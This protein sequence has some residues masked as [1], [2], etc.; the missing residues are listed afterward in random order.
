MVLASRALSNAGP[1]KEDRCI[2]A[3]C[4]L[5]GLELT[6]PAGRRAR[7]TQ[8]AGYI[9][10]VCWGTGIDAG[11]CELV[12]VLS[13]RTGLARSAI[14]GASSAIYITSEALGGIGIG[15]CGRRAL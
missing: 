4:A 3:G 6:G 14:I 13:R 10:E 7:L 15:I 12:E 11:E 1:R 5:G 2:R 9:F 8:L